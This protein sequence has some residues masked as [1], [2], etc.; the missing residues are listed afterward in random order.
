M[1]SLHYLSI[2]L[3]QTHNEYD[4]MEFQTWVEYMFHTW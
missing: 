3:L 1:A 2:R 4:Q